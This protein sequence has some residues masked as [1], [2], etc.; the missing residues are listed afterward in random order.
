VKGLSSKRSY[1]RFEFFSTI[2]SHKMMPCEGLI[3]FLIFFELVTPDLDP[4]EMAA[5]ENS[6]SRL[7]GSESCFNG[8][9]FMNKCCILDPKMI[10][11]KNEER[12]I[13]PLKCKHTTFPAESAGAYT[14][15]R[16]YLKRFA[17]RNE[18]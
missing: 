4:H 7:G 3:F 2:R 1:P 10:F 8:Q 11:S 9:S 15:F 6:R 13:S 12:I 16:I 17:C 18:S 5:R 14:K